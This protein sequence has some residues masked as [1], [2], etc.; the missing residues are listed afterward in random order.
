MSA[1]TMNSGTST[2]DT[3]AATDTQTRV[4]IAPWQFFFIAALGCSTAGLMLARGQSATTLVLL[5]VLVL[6]TVLVGVAAARTLVP[7][8]SPDEDRTVMVGH[9]TRVALE[10]EKAAVLRSIKEL[11]FD[12]AMGKLAEADFQ[13]MSSRLRQRATGLLRQLD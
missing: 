2:R 8:V 7:L 13:D 10:R 1:S 11:E 3:Q 9:R 6:S 4:G 12:R 5:A